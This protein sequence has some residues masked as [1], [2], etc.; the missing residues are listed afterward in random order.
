[1]ANPNT[2]TALL[3]NVPLENDYKNTLYFTSRAE[4]QAYFK[5]RMVRTYNDFS[6]QRKDEPVR[7]ATVDANG[8][9][10]EYDDL[11]NA[12]INYVMYK[13][14][15]YTDRWFY[16]FITDIKY[17]SDGIVE[18]YL[19][20]DVIQTWLF[21]YSVKSSFIER[22]HVSDDTLGKHTVPENIEYGD[23][24]CNGHLTDT[25]MDELFK[26]VCYIL[27]TT[28]TTIIEDDK[29]P[30]AGGRTYNGIFAG[31]KYYRFDTADAIATVL[32]MYAEAGQSDAVVGIFLAPKFLAPLDDGGLERTVAASGS[33]SS[34]NVSIDK[35]TTLNGYAPK[36]KKLLT[37]PYNYLVASNNNGSSAIYNYEEFKD[38]KCNFVVKGAICPGCSIRM[39]PKNYK[40]ATENDEESINL[41]KFPI[42]SYA[43]DMYTNWLTQNSINV[44]GLDITSDQL[45]IGGSALSSILQV[46]GGIG[47]MASGGGALAGA[48]MIANGLAGGISG[49]SNAVM[50]QKQH[51]LTPPQARGNTNCGD[52]I[53]SS[54]KNTFHFYQMS[55]KEEYARI[56]DNFFHMFGY[57]VNRVKIPNKAHRSRF[58]YTKTID[59]NITG[60][61]PNKDMQI[62]KNC[63]NNG[64]TF[65]RNASEIKNY[66]LDNAIAITDGA[67][68]E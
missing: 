37:Y 59:V 67:V 3:L 44:A 33:A 18:L 65:W 36:N 47:L 56:C 34:H 38:S 23:F 58:W 57:K 24:V 16:A 28:V 46:A 53:T 26:D 62:I 49:V 22:E 52:V 51:Q 6:Y 54:N 19:E 11:I 55:I 61:I 7:V 60:A 41:G 20:T 9:V 5:S 2:T 43:V 48:G 25:N 30:P 8:L 29:F 68:T 40:G 64:I 27:A 31:V 10:S 35:N 15:A 13:N 42:C 17:I 14:S 32:D 66:A 45:N 50:Q 63:Y 39:T 4:Q 21:D 12:G 1:M